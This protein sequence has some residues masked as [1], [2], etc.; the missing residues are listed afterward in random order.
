[1]PA[2]LREH[3]SYAADFLGRSA[4]E[5]SGVMRKHQLALADRQCRMA[6]VSAR[7]Q[8]GIV[9]LCTS[10]YA[11]RQN[12]ELVRAAADVVCQDLKRAIVGGR[13]EDRYFRTVT[14]L[15]ADIADGVFSPIAGMQADDIL[16]RYDS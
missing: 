6:E 9:M 7:V 5:I 13:P 8:N 1:M 12:D 10:L 16:M 14:K 3:A 11:A 4:M 15:G 2:A